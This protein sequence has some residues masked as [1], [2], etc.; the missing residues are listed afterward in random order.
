MEESSTETLESPRELRSEPGDLPDSYGETRAV[1]LPVEPYLVHVYWEVTSVE[2][3]KAK[4]QL[5]DEY[6]R[7]QTVLRCYDIT[8]IIF[9]GTNA[10]SSFDVHIDLKAKNRYVH[11]WSP[12]KSYFVELGFKTEGGRFF[13]IARSNIAETPPGWPAPKTDEHYMLVADIKNSS[14]AKVYE[15][16]FGDDGIAAGKVKATAEMGKA[17]PAPESLGSP[18]KSSKGKQQPS[19]KI[20]ERS[21]D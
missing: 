2:L 12:E 8:N 18:E 5:G 9:D 20:A 17:E 1:L 10:H 13:P 19:H 21:C 6:G 14:R 3:E 15:E 16:P 4:H 11:L 7:S